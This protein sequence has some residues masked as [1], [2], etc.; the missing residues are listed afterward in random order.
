M[1]V[2]S[3]W[4]YITNGLFVHGLNNIFL[5]KVHITPSNYHSIVNVPPK[6]PIV[7]ISPPKLP[8]NVNVPPKTNKKTKMT[9]IFLNKTNVLI[10]S[11][12]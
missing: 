1:S 9:I 11:K 4:C 12:N 10:N 6:L 2:V 7:S 5:G 3:S 8:K